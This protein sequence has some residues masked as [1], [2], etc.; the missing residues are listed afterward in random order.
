VTRYDFGLLELC[1]CYLVPLTLCWSLG[2]VIAPNSHFLQYTVTLLLSAWLIYK[3]TTNQKNIEHI[4]VLFAKQGE[5]KFA[6]DDQEVG[7]SE[8]IEPEIRCD[9]KEPTYLISSSSRC[10]QL[11]IF[12]LLTPT[13]DLTKNNP[14]KDKRLNKSSILFK[15]QVSENNY[16]YLALGINRKLTI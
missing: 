3:L 10:T 1:N 11:F 16:R 14:E 9:N 13:Q 4:K 12:L 8:L 2:S 5:P 7:Y 15:W 6:F